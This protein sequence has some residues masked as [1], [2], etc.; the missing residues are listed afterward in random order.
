V[1]IGFSLP[2]LAHVAAFALGIRRPFGFARC[3]AS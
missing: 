3:A 2:F 1:P